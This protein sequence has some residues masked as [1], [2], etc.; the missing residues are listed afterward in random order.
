MNDQTDH[1]LLI[2]IDQKLTDLNEEFRRVSNGT[3]FPRCEA[4][5][6][7]LEDLEAGQRELRGQQNWLV[8]LVAGALILAALNFLW[9]SS[10]P[11]EKTSCLP[12]KPIYA[13]RFHL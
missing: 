6:E 8:R 5:R 9:Q 3:G 7:R 11:L 1:D 13:A 2:T 10:R 12:K 4:R